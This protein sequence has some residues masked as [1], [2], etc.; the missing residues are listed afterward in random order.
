MLN[1]DARLEF[2]ISLYNTLMMHV[3]GFEKFSSY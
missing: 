1:D 3:R 2:W